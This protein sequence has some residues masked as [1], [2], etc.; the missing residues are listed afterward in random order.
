MGEPCWK[1]NLTS[2]ARARFGNLYVP[3][4]LFPKTLPLFGAQMPNNDLHIEQFGFTP[5]AGRANDEQA[6]SLQG[7][8]P[9]SPGATSVVLFPQRLILL[10]SFMV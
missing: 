10:R 7:A 5:T 1:R 8:S 3:L 6:L 9:N 2:G 4:A